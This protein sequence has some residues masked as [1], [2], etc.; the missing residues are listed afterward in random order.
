MAAGELPS[1]ALQVAQP[2]AQMRDVLYAFAALR[3]VALADEALHPA[4][5]L[6]LHAADGQ[7]RGHLP[8]AASI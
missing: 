2:A 8:Q 4:A 6:Q 3:H 7:R 1:G 5:V